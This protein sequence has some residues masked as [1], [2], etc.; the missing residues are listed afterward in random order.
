MGLGLEPNHQT[1]GLRERSQ[2]S[3]LLSFSITR[4]SLLSGAPSIIA[5]IRNSI[6]RSPTN[7]ERT[8]SVATTSLPVRSLKSP[9][10]RTR[11]SSNL[12]RTKKNKLSIKSKSPSN[13]EEQACDEDGETPRM[14]TYSDDPFA[15][16][17]P[18][19][20]PIT[21]QNQQ[22]NAAP[23]SAKARFINN[24]FRDSSSSLTLRRVS[25]S[26]TA[27]SPP[28]EEASQDRYRA[29]KSPLAQRSKRS[30]SL[31]RV[32]SYR[33]S[34]T[35]GSLKN[36]INET[37]STVSSTRMSSRITS[38]HLSEDISKEWSTAKL[39]L[40]TVELD[41]S[42]TSIETVSQQVHQLMREKINDEKVDHQIIG[43][44][45]THSP[46]L[47][48]KR[49]GNRGMLQKPAMEIVPNGL[50]KRPESTKDRMIRKIS[51]LSMVSLLKDQHSEKYTSKASGLSSSLSKSIRSV[52]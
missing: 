43:D 52:D 47:R 18:G 16:P 19:L 44:K 39:F 17:T 40:S 50:V 22:S 25:S 24:S 49:E 29:K 33:I 28:P 15:P 46:D 1:A 7:D 26:L 36:T 13:L 42:E 8:T 30:I 35:L 20:T 41:E 34:K 9:I 3:A 12:S 21:F 51:Q 38:F 11:K 6:A 23:S 5:S 32:D 31:S 2:D 10:I 48:E 45:I 14:R 37:T 4:H 27:F